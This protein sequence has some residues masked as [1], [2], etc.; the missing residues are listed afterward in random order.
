MRRLGRILFVCAGH[1]PAE[2][3]AEGCHILAVNR[4]R[5]VAGL[6]L[7]QELGADAANRRAGDEAFARQRPGR[8]GDPVDRVGPSIRICSGLTSLM[9]SCRSWID[10]ASHP[11]CRQDFTQTSR[12]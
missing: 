11:R 4:T 9:P 10:A 7:K 1:R 3:A 2:H 5:G 8:I 6:E 12:V